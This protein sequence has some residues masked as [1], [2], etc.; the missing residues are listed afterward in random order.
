MVRLSGRVV[1]KSVALLLALEKGK[2]NDKRKGRKERVGEKEKRDT[3]QHNLF[4]L[5][6]QANTSV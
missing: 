2:I 6:S 4:S 5:V 3:I 1:Y